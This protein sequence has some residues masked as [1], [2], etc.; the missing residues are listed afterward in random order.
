LGQIFKRFR[1]CIAS[2]VKSKFLK[3][4]LFQ[5]APYN[6]YLIHH[7]NLILEI[8]MHNQPVRHVQK[9]NRNASPKPAI[10]GALIA[11]YYIILVHDIFDPTPLGKMF[12]KTIYS[13]TGGIVF[14]AVAHA[15]IIL[16]FVS[17]PISLHTWRSKEIPL[18]CRLVAVGVPI[19]FITML[20]AGSLVVYHSV[21]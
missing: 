7:D 9:G 6:F 14:S 4:E 17:Y 10:L 1:K 2:T 18:L 20:I 16:L 11:I 21:H 3:D 15:Y 12:W 5:W 13:S 8:A 19:G